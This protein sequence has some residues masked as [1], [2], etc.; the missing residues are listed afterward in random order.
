MSIILDIIAAAVIGGIMLISIFSMMGNIN[1]ANFEK[2]LSTNV[3]G[4]I[5]T[6]ARIMESDFLKI[7]YH[8]KNDAIQSADSTGIA[9]KSD[10]QNNGSVATVQYLLGSS[11]TTTKNPNDRIIIRQ[12]GGQAI[13]ANVGLTYLQIAYFDTLGRQIQCPISTKARLDSIKAIRLKI[14]LESSEPVYSFVSNVAT[15]QSVYWEKTIYP[16]NLNK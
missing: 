3:Q 13:N 12:V 15:Y 7:G 1:Q 11:V 6:L 9:F 8:I 10:L 5:L 16:K 14:R 4:N 2:T